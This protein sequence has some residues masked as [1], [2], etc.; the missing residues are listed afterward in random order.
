MSTL[1]VDGGMVAS[2][3]LMQFQADVL[4]VPVVRPSSTRRPHSAPPSPPG[5]RVGFFEPRRDP[6]A[7]GRGT[8]LG[9]EDGWCAGLRGLLAGWREAVGGRCDATHCSG[10]TWLTRWK[11]GRTGVT[12]PTEQARLHSLVSTV[13][14]TGRAR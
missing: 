6:L 12:A 8:T 1:F 10:R 7:L 13:E 4:G 14:L 2:E 11:E 9:A 3:L 5:W